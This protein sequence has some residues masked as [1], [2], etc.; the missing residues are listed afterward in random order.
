MAKVNISMMTSLSYRS[1]EAYKSLRTNIELC[2]KDQHVIAITS[3]TPNEGK[4]SVS[5]NLA[6]SLAETGKRVILVDADLRKSVLHG[7][8]GIAERVL[9]LTNYLVGQCQLNDV[10]CGTNYPMFDLIMAG[11]VASNPAELLGGQTFVNMLEHLRNYYDY[12]IVD[13]PPLG[14]VIDSAIVAKECDGIAIVVAANTVSYRFVRKIKE[15]L[16][17]TDCKILGI[18]LNMVDMSNNSYYGKYYGRYYGKYYGK[19]GRDE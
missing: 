5:V 11:P 14:S 7:R 18:I 6:A 3:C 10:I 16:E 19:Y 4:S 12:I 15:Q 9:G 17:R 13:T 8:L 2:G 1:S